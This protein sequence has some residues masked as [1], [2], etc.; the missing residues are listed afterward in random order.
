MK[1][2]FPLV[3]LSVLESP[4]VAALAVSLS[5]LESEMESEIESEIGLLLCQLCLV[6]VRQLLLAVVCLSLVS[7]PQELRKELQVKSG[8]G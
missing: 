8:D 6:G 3:P 1:L 4:R 5:L 7:A 2:S